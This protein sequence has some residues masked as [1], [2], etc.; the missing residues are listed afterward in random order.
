MIHPGANDASA[1]RSIFVIDDKGKLSAMLYFPMS[2][3]RS[4]CALLDSPL[5]KG[6]SSLY[7]AKNLAYISSSHRCTRRKRH[8]A[9]PPGTSAFTVVPGDNKNLLPMHPSGNPRLRRGG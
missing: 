7:G 6:R 8:Y 9:S 2:N 1:V 4:I 3:G 5:M